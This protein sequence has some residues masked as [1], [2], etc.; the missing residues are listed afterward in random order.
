MKKAR[1]ATV[2]YG[3]ARPF[4]AHVFEGVKR[5]LK[6]GEKWNEFENNLGIVYDTAMAWFRDVHHQGHTCAYQD[7]SGVMKHWKGHK[8]LFDTD[9]YSANEEMAKKILEQEFK[10]QFST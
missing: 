8:A 6:E 9:L 5:E 10:L 3:P 1:P 4:G 2:P 7:L